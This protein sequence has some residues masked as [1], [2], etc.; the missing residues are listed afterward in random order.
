MEI[1]TFNIREIDGE[2]KAIVF[3]VYNPIVMN[4]TRKLLIAEQ[5]SIEMFRLNGLEFDQSDSFR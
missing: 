2:I 3:D 5:Q 4:L 1:Y